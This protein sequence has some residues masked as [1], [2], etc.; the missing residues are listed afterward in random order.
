MKQFDDPCIQIIFNPLPPPHTRLTTPTTANPAR[1]ACCS[2]E[3]KQPSDYRDVEEDAEALAPIMEG[4]E[5]KY[6]QYDWAE[7]PVLEPPEGAEN[8]IVQ[9]MFDAMGRQCGYELVVSGD[10]PSRKVI[11]ENSLLR[12]QVGE[13]RVFLPVAHH[14]RAKPPKAKK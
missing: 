12:W 8:T 7:D 2:I 10:V 14:M 1:H 13:G 11:A 9:V 3:K 6:A 5:G 4:T